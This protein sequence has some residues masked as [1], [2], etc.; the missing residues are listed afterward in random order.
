MIKKYSSKKLFSLFFLSGLAISV[1]ALDCENNLGSTSFELKSGVQSSPY[2]SIADVVID[3]P[4]G[5]NIETTLSDPSSLD[6]FSTLNTSVGAVV[7]NPYMLNDEDLSLFK[8][9]PGNMFVVNPKGDGRLFSI[10]ISGVKESSEFEVTY[11]LCNI[12]NP[13]TPE[14]EDAIPGYLK[15]NPGWKETVKLEEIKVGTNYYPSNKSCMDGIDYYGQDTPLTLADGCKT[16]SFKGSVS[17]GESDFTFDI[18][19]YYAILPLPFGIKDVKVTGCIVPKV[20]SRNGLNVCIGEY[21]NLSLDRDYKASSYEWMMKSPKGEFEPVGDN[22]NLIVE[23]NDMGAYSFCCLV[24][25]ISTDTIDINTKACCAINGIPTSRK[26]IFNDDFGY[27][28]DDH[29]YV[30]ANGNVQITPSSFAP[31]RADVDFEVPKHEFDNHGD[32]YDGYYS[33]VVPTPKGIATTNSL[34]YATWWSVLTTDHTS[35]ETGRKNG[36]A[37]LVNVAPAYKGVVYQRTV[38]GLCP[39]SEIMAESFIGDIGGGG[40]AA[41]FLIKDAET[42]AVIA[43]S[44][45]QNTLEY[46]GWHRIELLF[47]VPENVSSVLVEIETV[48]EKWTNGCDLVIDDVRLYTCSSPT[49]PLFINETLETSKTISENGSFT[50]EAPVSGL[51]TNYYGGKQ[52]YLFQHSSD[53]NN[54]KNV[55]VASSENTIEL[56]TSLF[57]DT[58]NYFRVIAASEST[59]KDLMEN[60]NILDEWSCD[61]AFSYSV[62]NL[63]DVTNLAP[64]INDTTS[65]SNTTNESRISYYVDGKKLVVNAAE[66]SN[67]MISTPLGLVLANVKMESSSVAFELKDQNL[68]ILVVDGIAYKVIVK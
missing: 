57:P 62:S 49:I 8:D 22:Q 53:K 34:G 26:C 33:I 28:V 39:G 17:K 16:Y 66:G 31:M 18:Y 37:F 56:E 12:L 24:D 30:D 13:N 50:L 2:Y 65:I 51:L 44:E 46:E 23:L 5:V 63:V 3:G 19:N 25:G 10:R 52:L 67:V 6:D 41:I 64:Q 60:S 35:L 58:I 42:G 14:L 40:S 47:I 45:I 1:Q 36:A 9:M 55:A 4:S 54:W 7:S 29:T 48:G 21:V 32:I 38:D 43:E 11:T 20:V 68:V 61:K 59:M 27:F 15:Q